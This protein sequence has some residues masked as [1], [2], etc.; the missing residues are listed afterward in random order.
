LDF[1][2][3]TVMTKPAPVAALDLDILAIANSST[4]S[5]FLE[6]TADAVRAKT[7]VEWD[8]SFGGR[9]TPAAMAGSRQLAC[10]KKKGGKRAGETLAAADV[11]APRGHQGPGVG[12]A[13]LRIETL[14]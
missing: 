11:A 10:P 6:E 12:A 8:V 7:D 4:I 1:K 5:R 13:M 14:H 3:S 2:I 9:R